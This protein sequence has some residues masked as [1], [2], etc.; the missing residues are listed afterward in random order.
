[1]RAV[2]L[3]LEMIVCRSI[4]ARVSPSAQD[5]VIRLSPGLDDH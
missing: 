4:A 3:D 1:M 5:Q 2:A